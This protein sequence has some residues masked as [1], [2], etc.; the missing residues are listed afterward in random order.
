LNY[1]LRKPLLHRCLA[2]VLVLGF[3]G[4]SSAADRVA[5]QNDVIESI[6]DG[7]RFGPIHVYRPSENIIGVV[8]FFSG[9]G[10]WEGGVI[11][12]A[13]R[14]ADEGYLV[15]GVDVQRYLASIHPKPAAPAITNGEGSACVS[16]SVDVVG[17]SQHLQRTVGL[18][19]YFRPTLFG[20]SAGAAVVYATLAQAPVGPF[21]G[22]VSLGFCS[23]MDFG[24]ATLCAGEGLHY[25]PV[26]HTNA[27]AN[28][29]AFTP[30]PKLAQAWTVV[31]GDRDNVCDA[32]ATRTFT[33]A[34]PSARLIALPQAG[35]DLQGTEAWWPRLRPDY[36]AMLVKDAT[37]NVR[38]SDSLEDLP[39]VEVPAK[40]EQGDLLAVMISGDG[41]WAGLDQ[42]LS[43]ELSTRSIPVVGLNSLKYFWHARSP[44]QTAT[45]VSRLIEHYA[46][47]W[48]KTRVLLIGYSFGADVMPS[49][50]NRLPVESRAR[51]TS[52][53]LL[54]L[55]QG[56]TFEVTVGEWLP[57]ARKKGT[58][59][60][61]EVARFGSTPALCIEGA[62]EKNSICP[63]LK[64]LG[65]EVQQIGEGHHF[66]GL[67]TDIADAIL[68]L[69]S[70]SGA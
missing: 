62:G 56:A 43:A 47:H 13:R 21:T 65:I 44:E 2:F 68:A 67:A 51:V 7:G 57:G 27:A 5:P 14:L 38:V 9:D 8:L 45:D 36:G 19:N 17:L 4:L 60:L 55:A 10:G 61:P 12:H 42:A 25:K 33:S 63:E 22:G 64:E 37:N 26:A 35:H 6:V 30:D 15:G 50:F 34:I 70:R 66:S 28:E 32:A 54:G 52:V 40:S 16:L 53:N 46:S 48:R 39:V 58:P 3:C 1:F 20:Y 29:V 18:P 23:E 24:G 69:A 49:V 59:V 41:G 11:S 31:H